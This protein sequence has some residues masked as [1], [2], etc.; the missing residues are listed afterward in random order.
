[1]TAYPHLEESKRYIGWTDA[2]VAGLRALVPVLE[3]HFD[4]FA[5]HFYEVVARHPRAMAVITGGP[6]QLDRLKVSLR[7][8]MVSGLQGPHDEQFYAKRS[9]IGRRHVA[10][11]LPQEYMFT[12]MNVLR[13]D[14]LGAVMDAL[15]DRTALRDAVAAIDRLFDL[16]L[17]IML[18]HYQLSSE[19]TLLERERR[20]QAERMIALQ[21]LTAGLAH[22]VRNPLNAAK[23]QLELL[24]RRLKRATDD[25]RLLE[26][27]GLIEHEIERLTRLLNDFLSFARPPQLVT[28]EHDLV[29]VVREV[30]ELERMV[31]EARGV[32]IEFQATTPPLIVEIDAG[33]IH[34]VVMNLVR[35]AIEAS[36]DGRVVVELAAAPAGI[37]IKVVDDGPGIPD[38]LRPRI[39]EPFFS[40]KPEGT[41]MGMTIVHSLVTAHGGT[42]DVDSAPGQGSVFTVT[43]P[44]R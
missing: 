14:Y 15:E 12:A 11:G 24:E 26:T 23:L 4:R 31:A 37:Q 29:S 18:R 1:M 3:P 40:T 44:R 16:E 17:A 21:T 39:Y 22:E 42:I 10:I 25:Q 36:R 28:D 8:W 43:L 19:E 30:I 34:Q 38:E 2:H 7:D 33:K 9:R 35:N 32:S 13:L 20:A 5:D 6:T 41:G 27:T